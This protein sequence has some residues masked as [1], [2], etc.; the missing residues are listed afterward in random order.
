MLPGVQL[1]FPWGGPRFSTAWTA[2]GGKAR[3][4][5]GQAEG[6]NLCRVLFSCQSLGVP[7][8]WYLGKATVKH[9]CPCVLAS[10]VLAHV[11]SGLGKASIC[12]PLAPR[13]NGFHRQ[14]LLGFSGPLPLV[15]ACRP[16][17]GLPLITR[18]FLSS[19]SISCSFSSKVL[20]SKPLSTALPPFWTLS[21]PGFTGGMALPEG[22][23]APGG[24]PLWILVS[25]STAGLLPL[26]ACKDQRGWRFFCELAG[27][28]KF[29]F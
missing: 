11:L 18:S 16:L 8:L 9:L 6:P 20:F 17:A 10:S 15:L 23:S 4:L 2:S 22:Q 19:H 29:S 25:A 28:W 3:F 5:C 13:H 7:G 21:S 26:R 12:V 27:I 24:S 1:T 14:S